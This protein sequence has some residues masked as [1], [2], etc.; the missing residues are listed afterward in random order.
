M[1]KNKPVNNPSIA[2]ALVSSGID[3][4]LRPSNWDEYI[5]QENIKKNI[6]VIIEAA[7]KRSEPIDHVL[8]YGQA[9]LG[10]TTL[11]YLI[12]NELKAQIK[13]TSGPALE[14]V[15]DIAAILSNLEPYDVLF[16]DEVH[17]INHLIEEAFYPALE[18]R[19]LHIMVGKGPSAR[20]VTLD[21]PP[22]TLIAATTRVN[23][24]SGPMRS[25]FGA[26]FKL[27]YYNTHDITK[28]IKRSAKVLNV[29]I[30]EPA[31]KI[32]AAAS[33]R[34]PRVAN[35]LLKR[36]R[37][38]A[39]V[40]G[41]GEVNAST[42][43][44]A[45]QFLGV[46]FLGLEDADRRFLETIIHKFNGGPVGVNALAAALNEDK[47]TIEDVYEPYLM[48]LGFLERT[49]AGRIAT[50]AAYEH[51]GVKTAGKLV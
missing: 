32:L 18:S 17:R 44:A 35:R 40:K 11:A 34:T 20:S 10:K 8:F 42:C 21:L 4:I 50:A 7:I 41:T 5:G 22:F 47:G 2:D 30:D 23:L 16:I 25:R 48:G 27:D 36:I 45:L 51:F 14:K 49:P 15:G 6:K 19:K 43:S 12:A 38:Y 31:I 13:T 29:A 9:G 1:S 46:D 37:D 26:T 24:L 33:R 28:I 3:Q 39:E